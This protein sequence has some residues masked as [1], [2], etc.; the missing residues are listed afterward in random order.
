MYKTDSCS[1]SSSAPQW[2][3]DT[4]IRDFSYNITILGLPIFSTISIFTSRVWIFYRKTAH[5]SQ[6]SL[7]ASSKK[8]IYT[9]TFLLQTLLTLIK[10][11]GSF[12]SVH[13]ITWKTLQTIKRNSNAFFLKLIKTHMAFKGN[14]LNS[15]SLIIKHDSQRGNEYCWWGLNDYRIASNIYKPNLRKR[16]ILAS[17]L[18]LNVVSLG[19]EKVRPVYTKM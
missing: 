5:I 8:S 17:T 2:T 6:P 4:Q 11:K 19:Q 14:T 12:N 3:S 16:K 15:H 18:S 9:N 7:D 1:T 13:D 10:N